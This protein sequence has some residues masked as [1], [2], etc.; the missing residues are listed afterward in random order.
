VSYLLKK[1]RAWKEAIG[2]PKPELPK[3]TTV[4]EAVDI[5]LQT[6]KL[7]HIDPQKIVDSLQQRLQ[8]SDMKPTIDPDIDAIANR[9]VFLGGFRV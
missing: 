9:D 5:I 7:L 1:L 2:G 6:A 8:E 3:R 4:D